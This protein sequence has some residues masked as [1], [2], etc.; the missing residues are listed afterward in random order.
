MSLR[1]GAHDGGRIYQAVGD[2]YI[3]EGLPVAPA[4]VTNTLP[5][6][7][8]AFEG[9]D[10]ELQKLVD[11]VR[12]ASA[13]RG[14]LPVYAIDGMPG[15]GK[16][17]FAVR[18]AHLLA[19]AFPD[20]TLFVN[21]HA[22]SAGQLPVEPVDVLGSLLSIAGV[23]AQY[24]PAGLDARAAM[25]RDRLAG[26]R[27]LLILDNAAGHHQVEPLLPGTDNCLNLVTS[28]RRLSAL[29]GAVSISLG[30]LAPD[31]AIN[32]LST[33]SGR[34]VSCE[35]AAADALVRLC[36]CLPLAVSMLAGR[37][38]HHPSWLL[39]DLIEDMADAQTRLD[40]L[41]AEDSAVAATFE[42]SYQDLPD[43]RKLFFRRLGLHPG[44][45]IDDWAAAALVGVPRSQARRH[46]AALY[47]DHLID[48]L[49]HG[50][51]RMHDLIR[52]Y[53][54]A[55]ADTDGEAGNEEAM[56][57]LFDY[58]QRTASLADR[59]LSHTLRTG[60]P[61]ISGVPS[62][63]DLATR[64]EAL[65][66]MESER[67]NLLA[68]AQRTI[69]HG[70]HPRV[71]RFAEA[72]AGYLQQA[73]PWDRAIEIH[74]AATA[75]AQRSADPS[76]QA[77]ALIRLATVQYLSGDYPQARE[78]LNRALGLYRDVSVL[79]GQASA[80]CHLGIIH[81]L[82]N[83]HE[84]ST[85]A[86]ERALSL[87]RH[88]GD[89]E[90]QADALTQLGIVRYWQSDYP[91]ASQLLEQALKLYRDVENLLGQANA[92]HHLGLVRWLLDDY[93]VAAE[94]LEKAMALHHDLGNR[95]GMAEAQ[96][97]LGAVWCTTG[98][99]EAAAEAQSEALT[100]FREMGSRFNE[101]EAL[102]NLGF[103]LLSAEEHDAAV[104][105]LE[106]ALVV[107][108]C[109]DSPLGEADV[110]WAL[111]SA[112]VRTG[113]LTLAAE[114]L[115]QSLTLYREMENSLGEAATLN[116]IGKLLFAS[117][118]HTQALEHHELALS[119]ARSLNSPFEEALALAGIGRHAH[120]EGETVVAI[121]HF[122]NAYAIL[123]RIGAAE[124]KNI[125]RE[126][127]DLLP[128]MLDERGK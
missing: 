26:K 74:R 24:I 40:E 94:V 33:L 72:M 69:Q 4:S 68:C 121:D 89:Q 92:L 2:Q 42:L 124:A 86:L 23:A 90:G 119:L 1:A 55:L 85:Q 97:W 10:G 106:E 28:R 61:S 15:V 127:A 82:T 88:L 19:D 22:H 84:V 116:E 21:L 14:P 41:R 36:G 126:L 66:W 44:E 34:D 32:L 93:P 95:I 117:G 39:G 102:Y 54:R 58:Y 29:D 81:K 65:K 57:H 77:R 3:Y 9:R 25:W 71:V 107:C 6:D 30:T 17:A 76:E 48:E 59:Q 98:R 108:R 115:D 103:T 73:G 16:T 64:T 87:Y 62:C 13:P 128:G 60:I 96:N 83:E 37:L 52:D 51:Y 50:R 111:G 113:A 75:A 114:L 49:R 122:R 100:V 5:R 56:G 63:P 104:K 12:H 125:Q 20:G 27:V 112:H 11:A 118:R 7:T 101:S 120:Y 35:E 46:L 53:T 31:E 18:A 70:Q 123:E 47:D 80:L 91:G 45:E 78:A 110:L 79:S 67:A 105:Y 99:Y 38:R 109:V 43:D 8:F